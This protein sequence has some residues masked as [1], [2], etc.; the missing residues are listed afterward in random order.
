MSR[1]KAPWSRGIRYGALFGGLAAGVSVTVIGR[2]WAACDV[3]VNA[4]SGSTVLL[5][6]APV[7]RVAAAVPWVLLQGTLGRRHQGA[8]LAAG[9]VL[10]VGFTWFLVTWLGMPDSYPDPVCPGNVPPWWPGFIPA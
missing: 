1:T 2:A 3:G 7:V 8:V 10:T 9:L 5:L 6:L 4:A